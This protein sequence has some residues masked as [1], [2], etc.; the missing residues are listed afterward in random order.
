MF[1]D[2]YR[3]GGQF[4]E[5]FVKICFRGHSRVMLWIFGESFFGGY[6]GYNRGILKNNFQGPSRI[7]IWIF[8]EQI[9]KD[10]QDYN[11]GFF[12]E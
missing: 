1:K 9:F 5:F 3:I 11:R 10:H 7:N 4:R 6:Y 2:S 12:K 8:K